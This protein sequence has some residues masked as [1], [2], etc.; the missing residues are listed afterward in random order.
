MTRP[1]PC[2]VPKRKARFLDP[3]LTTSPRC[4][5]STEWSGKLPSGHHWEDLPWESSIS[6]T[7]R[8]LRSRSCCGPSMKTP[9]P[10]SADPRRGGR[11]APRG[12]FCAHGRLFAPMPR[13]EVD[14][15]GMLSFPVPEAQLWPRYTETRGW[16]APTR[17]RRCGATPRAP[18]SSAAQPSRRSRATGRLPPTSTASAISAPTSG[19]LF[20]KDPAAQVAR[21]P[22]R[23]DLRAHL[24]RI[25][26]YNRLDIDHET[27]RRGRPYTLVCT[28]N[29]ASHKRRLAEYSKD[30]S[31]MRRLIRSAP[32]GPQV[33]DCAPDLARLQAA[34]AASR[35]K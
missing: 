15:A 18:C 30:V 20:C 31:W 27:E 32:G 7:A 25:I 11:P 14:G 16:R 21:F 24:H 35:R 4:A 2:P 28:K 33:T 34:V 8:T 29:R 12:D 19:R 26:K 6:N 13:L 23:T 10:P 22:L 5:T 3:A 17:S 1:S 9:T